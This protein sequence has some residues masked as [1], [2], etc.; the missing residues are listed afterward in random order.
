MARKTKNQENNEAL[1]YIGILLF[2][3]F[4]IISVISFS[5]L[6]REYLERGTEQRA[7]DIRR[8]VPTLVMAGGS[9]IL[10]CFVAYLG[11]S[12]GGTG[13]MVGVLAVLAG[14][15]GGYFVARRIAVLYLGVIADKERDALYF[16]YDM[17]SYTL[18]DY[19]SLRFL[20][21]YCHVDSVPLSA[22]N[23]LTRGRGKEL[24]AHGDFGSRGIIMSSKQKRDECLAMIQALTGKKGL[25]ITEIEGY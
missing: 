9:L 3:P 24:Y 23:K 7:M 20:R 16:P 11:F 10:C 14:L 4:L 2:L 22:I 5:A 17:Q 6:K 19:F 21:D 13:T 25:L 12:S 8:L 1:G 18:T 15:V